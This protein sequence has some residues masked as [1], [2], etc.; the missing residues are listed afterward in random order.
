M[1][2]IVKEGLSRMDR[3]L[4]RWMLWE[5]EILLKKTIGSKSKIFGSD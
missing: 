2:M 4:K 5:V 3:F 1:L